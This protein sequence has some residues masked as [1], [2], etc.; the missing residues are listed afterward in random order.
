MN[1]PLTSP[2]RL[3]LMRARMGPYSN[4][5]G[6]SQTRDGPLQAMAGRPEAASEPL[7][8]PL[9]TPDDPDAVDACIRAHTGVA[10]ATTP[11][12]PAPVI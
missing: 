11:P 4:T 9:I 5:S 3:K 8:R 7:V 1:S 2:E 6:I 10:A 12:A